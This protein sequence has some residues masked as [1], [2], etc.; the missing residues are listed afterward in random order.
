MHI[1]PKLHAAAT[2]VSLVKPPIL[3]G[4][5]MASL[6]FESNHQLL[7]HIWKGKKKKGEE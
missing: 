3:P 1:S 5:K 2:N 6:G 7:G 4:E